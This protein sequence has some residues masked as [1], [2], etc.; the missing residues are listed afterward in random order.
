MKNFFKTQ[1]L[2][3][4]AAIVSS[5]G[6]QPHYLDRSE[7]ARIYFSFERAEKL[8]SFLEKYWRRELKIEPISFAM[9]QKFLKNQIFNR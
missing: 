7:A 6:Q 8:D 9:A 1:D 5:F 4:A 3:L 2:N